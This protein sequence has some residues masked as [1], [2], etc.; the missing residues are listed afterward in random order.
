VGKAD[1]YNV[2]VSVSRNAAI[3]DYSV[4]DKLYVPTASGANVPLKNVATI[5]MESSP[6]QIRHYDKD[7]YV[8]VSSFVKPGYNVQRMNEEITTKLNRF[9]FEKGQTFTVAGKKKVRKKV[10]VDWA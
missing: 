2:N 1:N 5:E 10:L 9:K 4:F 6:N 8:T 7:R 3:Q